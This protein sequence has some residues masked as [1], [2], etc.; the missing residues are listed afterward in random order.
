MRI[1]GSE[2][3][4]A[5]PACS[6]PTTSSL[7]NKEDALVQQR[8]CIVMVRGL[9]GGLSLVVYSTKQAWSVGSI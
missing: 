7:M 3:S 8:L 5:V 1:G 9:A 4:T 6:P 2:L